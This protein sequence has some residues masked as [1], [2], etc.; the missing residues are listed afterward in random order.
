[1]IFE[2]MENIGSLTQDPI[3]ATVYGGVI[4]GIGMGLIIKSG[5]ST[6]GTDVIAIILNKKF[7]WPLSI[8]MYG[9]DGLILISQVIFAPSAEVILLGIIVTFLY[10]MIVEKVVLMGG[11]ALQLFVI[12]KKHEEIR[13]RLASMIVGNTI[14]HG[15]SGYQAEATDVIMCV[16]NGRE[17]HGVQAAI[18]DIDPEAF[19]TISAVKEVKGRGYSF[20]HGLAKQ[21][22][23]EQGK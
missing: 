11:G 9:I 3:I 23:K 2:S 20:D 14:L 7:G 10:S 16:T 17:L 22:R 15:Q 1:G 18:L 8:P 21:M 6:G 4:C 12:S 5:A 19:I 13:Q